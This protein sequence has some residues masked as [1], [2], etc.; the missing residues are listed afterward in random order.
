MLSLE[1]AIDP[2]LGRFVSGVF[3]QCVEAWILRFMVFRS[4]VLIS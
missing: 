3:S 4:L 2:E 1:A